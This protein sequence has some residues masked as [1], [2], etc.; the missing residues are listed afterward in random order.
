MRRPINWVV[1]CLSLLFL[2]ANL[3][4]GRRPAPDVVQLSAAPTVA[5]LD[6]SRVIVAEPDVPQFGYIRDDGSFLP[7]V[8]ETSWS[9]R[10]AG[11]AAALISASPSW[12]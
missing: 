6:F 4:S 8:D 5:P 1:V 10:L 11:D 7:L 12:Q 9:P 2:V 3:S